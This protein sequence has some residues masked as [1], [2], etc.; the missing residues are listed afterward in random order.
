MTESNVCPGSTVSWYAFT[1]PAEALCAQPD[2]DR[3]CP[4]KHGNTSPFLATVM[5]P[6]TSNQVSMA[7]RIAF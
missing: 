6:F 3:F 2:Y 4:C 5:W 7:R 1:D